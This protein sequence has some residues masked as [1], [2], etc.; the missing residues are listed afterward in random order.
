MLEVERKARVRDPGPI[1]V[2][3]EA[4]GSFS[5]EIVKED[6]YY[7]VGWEPGR[8]I[9][10]ASDPIFRLRLAGGRA[11]IGWK[12]R[13]FEGTTEVNEERQF[14]LDDPDA[15]IE[16]LE[17]TLGLV[18]FVV[19]HKRT[20]LF[21][22]DADLAPARVE[23]NH[24]ESLGHFVE[25]EVLCEPGARQEAVRVIDEVFAALA[26]PDEAVETRYY[27]DL[28]MHPE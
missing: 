22:L 19:K 13:T 6:R 9:D 4:L 28:L 10:F 11:E 1:E 3:L 23:L 14:G 26:I 12:S 2:R 8:A 25:V 16:W 21:V 5:G 17:S 20:R 24:V 27:V 7:L 18:P 15:A